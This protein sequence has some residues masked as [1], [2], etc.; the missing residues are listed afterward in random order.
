MADNFYSS[1]QDFTSSGKVL[2][3]PSAVD[4][5]VLRGWEKSTLKGHNSA[6]RKFLVYTRH[7]KKSKFA[8]P[9]S[10]EDIYGFCAWAGRSQD[11]D[12]DHKIS[13][14]TL[15]KYVGSL[16]S[17]HMYHDEPFPEISDKKIALMVKGAAKED[18]KRP[19][20]RSKPA[21]MI[22]DLIKLVAELAEGPEEH[23]AI[24]DLVIVAFWG[25]ARLGELNGET[26]TLTLRNA[27]TAAP[28]ELQYIHVRRLNHM[29]CPVLALRR[30]CATKPSE[31]ALFSFQTA[32]A[33]NNLTRYSVT[34]TI[35]RV[36]TS[37]G[38]PELSGHSFRV[39]GALLR[40]AL[41]ISISN[42]CVLERWK[43]KSYL[44]YLR[45]YNLSQTTEAVKLLKALK[46][47]WNETL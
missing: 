34:S 13:S 18:A 22:R 38:R 44:L 47:A 8:L 43:S 36:W 30:R 37:I 28:G 10:P 14:G 19:K 11:G 40:N 27:K 31:S 24:M 20:G 4:L 21:V 12:G 5:G 32:S 17:W 2:R 46:D 45:P 25:M 1:I 29:L 39:G 35:G 41:G 33:T 23:I 26:A 9:A 42:I 3:T 6:V 16:K 15:A 7:V